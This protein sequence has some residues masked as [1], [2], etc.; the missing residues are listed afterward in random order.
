MRAERGGLIASALLLAGG[1]GL[2]AA[3]LAGAIGPLV[4][5][6][7]LT[8]PLAPGHWMAWTGVGAL[9]F[10]VIATLLVVMIL[11][12]ALAPETP[13]RGALGIETTP[14][15]RLFI[16]L[17]GAAYLHLAWLGLVGAPLW[18]A[19]ALS[20]VLAAAVFRWV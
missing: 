15:D 20:L 3:W 14:G 17:L 2:G 7:D 4:A 5:G 10:G 13:R 18:G 6:L 8:K 11:W 19:L 9:F 12:G 1:G 16:S